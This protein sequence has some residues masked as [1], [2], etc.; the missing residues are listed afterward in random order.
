[1]ASTTTG[2]KSWERTRRVPATRSGP[3]WPRRLLK[4]DAAPFINSLLAGEPPGELQQHAAIAW[5]H[6]PGEVCQLPVLS[7]LFGYIFQAELFRLEEGVLVVEGGVVEELSGRHSQGVGDRL[8]DVGGGVLTALLDVTEVALGDS[9][10]VGQSLQ[11]EVSVRAEPA[12][13]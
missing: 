9:G 5:P 1:M 8:D 3:L 7:I 6:A 10:F 11:G 13:C 2:S 12:D 4:N